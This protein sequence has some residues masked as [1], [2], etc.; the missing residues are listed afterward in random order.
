M[1]ESYLIY[2]CRTDT[3]EHRDLLLALLGAGPFDSFEERGETQLD[4][5]VPESERST[6]ED[7]I[8][9]AAQRL[10]VEFTTSE[11]PYQ[12]WNATWESNFS[13]VRVGDFAAI[14][15]SF[16]T[17]IPDVEHELVIDPRMAFGTGHHATTW[18]MMDLMRE[19]DWSDSRVLDY[20]CGT[21][22]LAVLAA[23]LGATDVAAVDIE[24]ESYLNTLDNIEINA[25]Q[26]IRT[27]EGTL[28]TVPAGAPYDFILANINRNVILDSLGTLYQQLRA[29]GHL[30]VSGILS[31]DGA[32]VEKAAEQCGFD[33]MVR[34]QREDWLAWVFRR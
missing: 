14:R 8:Q 28:E 22:V 25:V 7:C 3:A 2:H 1:G 9:A 6:A 19:Q 17:P 23:R 15:A 21:G 16:H 12:N 31:K 27:Y 32:R 10:A 26:G 4:A 11:L 24:H 13:P 5:Y 33:L 29:G 18:M 20:G 34:R 30:F